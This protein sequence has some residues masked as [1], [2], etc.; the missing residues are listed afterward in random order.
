MGYEE[1][2]MGRKGRH[3]LGVVDSE[4]ETSGAPF[5]QVEGRLGLERTSGSGAVAGDDVTTVEEGNG[6][7]LSVAR[8][9]DNHLVVGLEAWSS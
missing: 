3:V 9:T 8:V 1:K 4:L 2:G 5:D 6:H 7:V